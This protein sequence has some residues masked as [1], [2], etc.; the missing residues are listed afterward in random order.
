MPTP[1]V[2]LLTK[3]GYRQ[4]G[5]SRG[6][7]LLLLGLDTVCRQGGEGWPKKFLISAGS[8]DHDSGGHAMPR[9]DAVDVRTRKHGTRPWVFRDG[10]VKRQFLQRWAV[11]LDDGPILRTWEHST[12]VVTAHYFLWLESEGK[13][14]EHVHGQVRRGT[15]IR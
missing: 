5:F 7:I 10:R 6:L 12:K 14:R 15:T 4:A 11:A 13:A 2:V 3:A 9:C 8:N 1:K